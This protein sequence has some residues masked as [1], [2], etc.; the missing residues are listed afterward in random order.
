MEKKAKHT[1]GP[2]M[3]Q[4]QWSTNRGMAE[5]IEAKDWGIIGAWIDIGNEKYANAKLIAAAPELLKA[6]ELA[7]GYIDANRDKDDPVSDEAWL[8]GT[9]RAAIAKA[10]E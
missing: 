10:T 5:C 2:W 7:E 1:P 9:I 3:I 8:L 6:L 4:G